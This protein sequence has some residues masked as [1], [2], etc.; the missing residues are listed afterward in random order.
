[1]K[2][3]YIQ[4]YFKTPAEPGS[5][6]SYWISKELLRH[7]YSVTVICQ[8][9]P[10]AGSTQTKLVA[11]SNVEGIEVVSIRNSYANNMGTFRRIVSFVRFMMLSLRYVLSEKEVGLLF[12]SS[13]PLTVAFPA[14]VRKF[15]K[16]TP[17]IFEVRDLWP[18]APIQ[19]KFIKNPL[20]IRFLRWFERRTY[21]LAEH[22]ITL[23][24]GMREGVA[25]HIPLEK[26]SMIPNMSKIDKFWQ[27]DKNQDINSRFGLHRDTFK[28]V[29]FGTFGV[30]NGLDYLMDVIKILEKEGQ[31]DV[32]FVFM[33]DGIKRD[34]LLSLSR[35][36][37]AVRLTVLDRQPMDLVSAIVNNCDVCVCT[38]SDIPI[39]KT[40]SPNKL[41]DSLSAGKP[42]IVNSDGW[43]KDIV[44]NYECGFY[45]DPRNP[46]EM[47]EKILFLKDNPDICK[48]QGDNARVLA[49][50][51]FDKSVLCSQIVEIFN[52]YAP[53][54]HIEH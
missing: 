34:D 19:L 49:E 29:Y 45:V 3:L 5:T 50:T 23:S 20:L 16:K 40:N 2:I 9:N 22:V 35:Q 4:Q 27:R 26:T 21:Q 53:T 18:E 42:S 51:K 7:G 37:S 48:K 47:A 6:R 10:L 30:A 14:M 54:S 43:T 32:E 1:M 31:R 39:L 12:A 33:G 15:L 52:R 8:A 17:Y 41:F 28:L 38:F 13:T 44:E 36:L 11:R 46:N 24:P 25:K